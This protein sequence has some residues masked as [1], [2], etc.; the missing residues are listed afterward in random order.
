[1]K[2]DDEWLASLV[3]IYGIKI[4]KCLILSSFTTNKLCTPHQSFG[5]FCD[6][7]CSLSTTLGL[8]LPSW[9]RKFSEMEIWKTQYTGGTSGHGMEGAGCIKR[10]VLLWLHTKGAAKDAS[11]RRPVLFPT[12]SLP[13]QENHYWHD[14]FVEEW[15]RAIWCLL[16][17]SEVK[18]W[19]FT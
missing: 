16:Q 8:I 12:P 17:I 19:E 18:Y 14:V 4:K 2:G 11:C 15:H 7:L 3:E 5:L 13:L 10:I 9:W 6:L 1:M